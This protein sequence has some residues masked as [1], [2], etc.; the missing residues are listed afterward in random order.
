[1]SWL[2]WALSGEKL[3]GL[4][5]SIVAIFGGFGRWFWKRVSS[6]VDT[7]VSSLMSGHKNIEHRLKAVEDDVSSVQSKITSLDGDVRG[8]AMR[9]N[10][11]SSKEDVHRVSVNLARLEEKSSATNTMV[12]S[13]YQGMMA[14]AR[15][16][17]KD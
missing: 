6:R 3:V 16:D 15:P 5:L 14:M 9:I 13:L 10:Q 8:M 11:L 12:D 4:L 17:R 2:E 7:G 1:M